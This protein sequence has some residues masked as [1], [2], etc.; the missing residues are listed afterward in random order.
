MEAKRRNEQLLLPF[1]EV[2]A[3]EARGNHRQGVEASTVS[4]ET[5]RPVLPTHNRPNRRVRTRTHG[6]V[7]GVGPQGPPLSRSRD[8]SRGNARASIIESP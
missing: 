3:G 6:G 2:E 7:G 8:V 4:C 1:T 5:E